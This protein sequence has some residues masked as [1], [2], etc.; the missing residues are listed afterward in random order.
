MCIHV[1]RVVFGWEHS[2]FQMYQH[3]RW[4][5]QKSIPM[6][7]IQ[8]FL[9]LIIRRQIVTLILFLKTIIHSTTQWLFEFVLIFIKGQ[10]WPFFQI[11]KYLAKIKAAAAWGPPSAQCSQKALNTPCSALTHSALHYFFKAMCTL[12]YLLYYYT[13]GLLQ[14]SELSN[15][16][17]SRILLLLL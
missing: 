8:E 16:S 4:R 17:S 2:S 7:T 13:E 15:L 1:K 5:P 10:K 9:F 12:V 11:A 14:R 6:N 3:Q